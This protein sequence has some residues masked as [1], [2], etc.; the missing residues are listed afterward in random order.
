VDAGVLGQVERAGRKAAATPRL[1]H[2]R[3]HRQRGDGSQARM[4]RRPAHSA[5]SASIGP[6]TTTAFQSDAGARVMSQCVAAT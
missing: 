2:E 1:D 3:Q 6:T 5:A 4:P